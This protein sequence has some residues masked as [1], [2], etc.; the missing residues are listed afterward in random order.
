MLVL[1][2]QRRVDRLDD[3]QARCAEL[4]IS[5]RRWAQPVV[6]S[7]CMRASQSSRVGDLGGGRQ[8]L[9]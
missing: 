5:H 6:S 8:G 3:H 4:A 2:V 9:R 7:G 1:V